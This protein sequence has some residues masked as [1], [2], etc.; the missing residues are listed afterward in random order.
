[1]VRLHLKHEDGF[2]DNTGVNGASCAE[3]FQ[4]LLSWEI[5]IELYAL[6]SFKAEEASMITQV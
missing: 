6:T 2:Y 1:M 5:Y 3:E 4:F